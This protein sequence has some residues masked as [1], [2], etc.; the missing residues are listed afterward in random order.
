MKLTNAIGNLMT[1]Y[2]L[3][4]RE[5]L[6]IYAGAT[7]GALAPIA[8]VRYSIFKGVEGTPTQEAIAWTASAIGSVPLSIAGGIIGIHLGFSSALLLKNGR[9][10]KEELNEAKKLEDM[11]K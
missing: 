7:L 2:Q 3:N 6:N 10:K 8:F 11:I 4:M 5:K 1:E 9:T